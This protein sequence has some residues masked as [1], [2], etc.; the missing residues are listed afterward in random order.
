MLNFVFNHKTFDSRKSNNQDSFLDAYK[1]IGSFKLNKISFIDEENVVTV[2]NK[3]FDYNKERNH[4]IDFSKL[5]P[6]GKSFF[7]S[8]SNDFSNIDKV[9]D[10]LLDYWRKTF[11]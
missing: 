4:L 5:L 11:Q 9:L 8:I 1:N 6:D 10:F 2:M 7:T 3:I